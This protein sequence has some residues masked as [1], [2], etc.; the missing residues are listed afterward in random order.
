MLSDIRFRL[1]EIR[2]N[3]QLEV[4]VP[5]YPRFVAAAR[6]LGGILI[7]TSDSSEHWHFA[8]SVEARVRELCI[9]TWGTDGTLHKNSDLVTLHWQPDD[10]RWDKE[11]WLAGRLIALRPYRDSSVQLGWGVTV[12]QGGFPGRG[13]SIKN[14]ALDPH[15]DTIVEILHVPRGIAEITR[16]DT[17]N[18]TIVEPETPGQ[19]VS[20]AALRARR[21]ELLD[22]L[23]ILNQVLAD[24]KGPAAEPLPCRCGSHECPPD[25]YTTA[26]I[27]EIAP[28]TRQTVIQW[29]KNGTLPAVKYGKNWIVL[30]PLPKYVRGIELP[31][32]PQPGTDR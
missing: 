4:R 23:A 6:L 22:E 19:P 11:A 1:K 9:S 27:A 7:K 26:E 32:A 8:P 18:V 2:S 17:P 29:C 12:V 21:D 25:G 20:H 5:H 31:A 14:P 3:Y 24:K 15:D 30:R 28:V 10:L 16:R 13:G